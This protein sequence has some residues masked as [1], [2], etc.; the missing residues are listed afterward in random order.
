MTLDPHTQGF[1]DALGRIDKRKK[2]NLMPIYDYKCKTC[3][4]KMSVIRK[5]DEKERTPL[6]ANCVKDLVRV[7]D[8]PAVAFK[9]T[10]W[11]KDG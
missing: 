10:G 3:D 9:G 7:Y 1:L 4:L 2:R 11:G 5:I 6:C 8:T